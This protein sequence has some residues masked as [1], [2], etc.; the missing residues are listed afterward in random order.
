MKRLMRWID[1]WMVI[2]LMVGG[3]G[4]ALLGWQVWPEPPKLVIELTVVDVLT[5]ETVDGRL[6]MAQA[7]LVDD[8]D[9]L[10]RTFSNDERC[11]GNCTAVV[12]TNHADHAY[13]LLIVAE[14]Y[15]QWAKE[16]EF[17]GE[18]DKTL[19][20][21]ATLA[22]EH[23][24]LIDVTVTAID[25][26]TG[27]AVVADF[28]LYQQKLDSD[29]TIVDS[30]MLAC[31]EVEQCVLED[32]PPPSA[33]YVWQVRARAVGYLDSIFVVDEWQDLDWVMPLVEGGEA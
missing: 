3:L 32:L 28:Y 27:T 8:L 26:Q 4:G 18:R 21:T 6:Y 5:A 7:P 12:G 25:K 2:A 10:D 16:I 13:Y 22:P 19:Q 23:S 29:L 30:F 33:G 31:E 15:E 24:D 17:R 20:L 1:W 11:S 9:E 14:G